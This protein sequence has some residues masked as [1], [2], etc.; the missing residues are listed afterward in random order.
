[1]AREQSVGL[2]FRQAAK[3]RHLFYREPL[4][5]PEAVDWSGFTKSKKPPKVERT[6]GSFCYY[7]II[8]PKWSSTA[9]RPSS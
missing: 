1:M 6:L 7:S 5:P 9:D 4:P 2:E 8:F 3:L